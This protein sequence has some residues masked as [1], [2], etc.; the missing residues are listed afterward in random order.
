MT[1]ALLL[2]LIALALVDSMSF[3]TL[4]IPVYML[5]VADRFRA[6]RMFVYLGTLATFYFLIGVAL[7]LGLTAFMENFQDALQSRTAYWVQLALGVGLFALSF[8]FDPKRRE[9]QGKP[10]RRLEPRLGGPGG[11]VALA[12]T[13]GVLEVATMVPYL[14]AIGMMTN[15]SLPATQW[16]PILA[17]YV[18]VMITPP[19]LLMGLRGIVGGWLAPKL[20]RLRNWITKNSESMVGWALGIVGFLLARDAAFYIFF[21]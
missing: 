14:A 18:L 13:A 19:L 6:S 17:A 5:V 3:G 21:K 1:T 12:L 11:M 15:A 7:L 9:K 4:G 16:L 2:T 8:K 20:E 10:S